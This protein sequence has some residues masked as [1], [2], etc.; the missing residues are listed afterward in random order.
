MNQIMKKLKNKSKNQYHPLKNY[1]NLQKILK[2]YLLTSTY[3]Y[4]NIRLNKLYYQITKEKL[5]SLERLWI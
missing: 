4:Q 5:A 1:H 2:K 3:T